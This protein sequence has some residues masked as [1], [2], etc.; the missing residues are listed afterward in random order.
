MELKAYIVKK[1][2]DTKSKDE[3]AEL[4]AGHIGRS[5]DRDQWAQMQRDDQKKERLNEKSN[6]EDTQA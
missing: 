2:L 1:L 5:P 6:Q 3:L 4:L